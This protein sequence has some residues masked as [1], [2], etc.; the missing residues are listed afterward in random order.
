MIISFKIP[1][2][3]YPNRAFL[4]Q[5]YNNANLRALILKNAAQNTEKGIFGPDLRN[6]FLHKL[7]GADFK[8]D[9]GILKIPAQKKPR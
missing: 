7:E 4:N 1:A 9:N 5:L 2:K 8:Y 6:L 3:K